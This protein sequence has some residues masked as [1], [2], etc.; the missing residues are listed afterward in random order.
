MTSATFTAYA[1]TVDG[2]GDLEVIVERRPSPSGRALSPE[3]FSSARSAPQAEGYDP[4]TVL[5]SLGYRRVS[6][7]TLTDWGAVCDAEANDA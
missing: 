5:A 7:W 1:I 3:E 2:Y 4:D 6:E